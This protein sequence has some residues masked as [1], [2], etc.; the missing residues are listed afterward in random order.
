MALSTAAADAGFDRV[1]Q[2]SLIDSSSTARNYFSRK[3]ARITLT[4]LYPL[5]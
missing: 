2:T 5:T 4:H 1:V 3:D